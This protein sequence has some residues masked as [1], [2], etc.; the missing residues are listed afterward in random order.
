MTRLCSLETVVITC[1]ILLLNKISSVLNLEDVFFNGNFSVNLSNIFSEN[2]VKINDLKISTAYLFDLPPP[3]DLDLALSALK[4][5]RSIGVRN[6]NVESKTRGSDRGRDDGFMED[7]I[8]IEV[9]NSYVGEHIQWNKVSKQNFFKM[10]MQK[11]DVMKGMPMPYEINNIADA[12]KEINFYFNQRRNG[13]YEEIVYN[14]TH[15]PD[16]YTNVFIIIV[17]SFMYLFCFKTI[18][19]GYTRGKNA[20]KNYIPKASTL[21]FFFLILKNVLSYFPAILS[22]IVCLIITFYFYSISMNPCEQIYFLKNSTIKKEPIG[23]VLIVFAESIIIGNILYHFFCTP[24]MLLIL[25]RYIPSELLVRFICFLI[26]LLI[27]YTI[28]L[29]MISNLISA[30]KAQNFVFSFTSSYLIVSSCTYFYNLLV[31]RVL[32]YTNIFQIEPIMFFSYAPKFVFNIQ[33]YIALLTIFILTA[34]SIYIPKFIKIKKDGL[35]HE[36][37]NK[38]DSS[39][40]GHNRYD[41]ILSSFS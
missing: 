12:I 10:E 31:L 26:L 41:I 19:E 2:H 23:W 25:L 29:L 32:K 21:F 11:E 17:I 34:L 5:V 22:S 38:E 20:A 4:G 36:K 8:T 33:N 18:C 39:T 14:G 37:R 13:I 24:H 3:L 9:E 35:R 16:I 15:I 7:E 6:S 27:G 28:F 40:G 1:L 30:K